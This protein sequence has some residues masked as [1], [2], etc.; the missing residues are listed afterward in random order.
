MSI[1]KYILE[2]KNMS[3]LYINSRMQ[4][5][6]TYT[7][8]RP[9][10]RIPAFVHTAAHMLGTGNSG[11]NLSLS[12]PLAASR[13]QLQVNAIWHLEAKGIIPAQNVQGAGF[14]PYCRIWDYQN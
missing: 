3:D 12:K 7:Y 14:D 11:A 8:T 2:L 5:G 10:L 1:L 13:E 4:A 6:W 9:E